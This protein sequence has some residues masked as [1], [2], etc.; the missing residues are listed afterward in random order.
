MKRTQLLDACRNIEK[1]I[2]SY[3]SILVIAMIAVVAYLG[4]ICPST[5]LGKGASDYFNKY[6]LWDLEVLSTLLM[7]DSDLD[8]IRA[9]D[10]VEYV[11]RVYQAHAEL[12]K[13][14]AKKSISVVSVPE[15]LSLPEMLTGRLP[16]TACINT[17]KAVWNGTAAARNISTA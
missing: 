6:R 16:E 5:A 9:I 15:K 17:T 7:D 1:E 12:M 10:G 14:S 4:V 2:I 3:I 8:A 13:K 11:E